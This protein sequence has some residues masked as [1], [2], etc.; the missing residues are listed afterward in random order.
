MK[1]IILAIVLFVSVTVARA[2]SESY[3][4]L[5]DSAVIRV[6][7]ETRKFATDVLHLKTGND[8]Y[9]WEIDSLTGYIKAKTVKQM[10][11][12]VYAYDP[13]TKKSPLEGAFQ[14]YGNNE[15]GA[16]KFADSLQQAGH[17]I[18]LYKTAGT[19]AAKITARMLDYS[20]MSICF[21]LLH[22]AVHR[23]R[24]NTSSG[25]PYVFEEAL[26]DLVAN[27][28]LFDLRA[29]SF[30]KSPLLFVYNSVNEKLYALVNETAAGKI[31]LKK[32]NKKLKSI[33]SHA[34]AFQRD[35]FGYTINHAYLER[36][37]SY[38]K[39]YFLL[40]NALNKTGNHQKFLEQV[41]ALT[42]TEEEVEQALRKMAEGK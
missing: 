27:Q 34:D 11:C 19:S 29:V 35:R 4:M 8:F 28:H 6:M 1:K 41:F 10:Y 33:L 37:R 2:Q 40:K 7:D 9:A 24:G 36:Y 12:Y 42:G 31:S 5:T 22:E 17:E 18:M 38:C 15:T 16:K 23:H 13:R 20:P 30:D 21:I 3:T 32:A 14:Y 25:L 39:H 26:C